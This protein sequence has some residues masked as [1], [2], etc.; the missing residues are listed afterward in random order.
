MMREGLQD[1]FPGE[2]TVHTP[3]RA[4]KDVADPSCA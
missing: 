2:A 3:A 1:F 4:A